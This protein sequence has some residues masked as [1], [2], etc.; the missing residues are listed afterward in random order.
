MRS[1]LQCFMIVIVFAWLPI[2]VSAQQQGGGG[3]SGFEGGNGEFGGNRVSSREDIVDSRT[4][5][6]TGENNTSLG[7]DQ[8]NANNMNFLNSLFSGAGAANQNAS[9][10]SA[11]KGRGIRAPLRL[12]FQFSST[13]VTT[14]QKALGARILR[15]PR[16]K[17][18]KIIAV[19][20][21]KTLIL[22]G[23]V[24]SM[25]EASLAGRIARFEPGIDQV[26]NLLKVS[27]SGK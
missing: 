13:S 7:G 22:N 27:N 15:I 1:V 8:A 19:V 17:D 18:K 4:A 2:N 9:Q 12:G 10:N 11:L 14:G 16:F 25:E 26:K 23:E 21:G 6:N 20:Q 24:G 5:T 3:E